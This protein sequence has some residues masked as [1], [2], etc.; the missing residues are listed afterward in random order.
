M[1]TSA[2]PRRGRP[3]TVVITHAER[4]YDEQVRSRRSRYL[5]MMGMRIPLLVAGFACL[6]TPWLAILLIVLSVPLPWIAVL[7]ANDRPARTSRKV[8]PGVINYERAL[9]GPPR[10]IVDSE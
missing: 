8:L 6:H 7:I 4:S 3:E 5:I 1:S 2:E 10:E 9:P